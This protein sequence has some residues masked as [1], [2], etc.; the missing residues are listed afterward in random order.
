MKL[1]GGRGIL[2]IYFSLFLYSF[3]AQN[4]NSVKMYEELNL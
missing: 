4:L 1:L 3:V 2:I